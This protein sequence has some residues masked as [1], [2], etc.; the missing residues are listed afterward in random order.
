MHRWPALPTAPNT[1][2]GIAIH[3]IVYDSQNKPI[4]YIIRDINP[5][6]EKILSIK[7]KDVINKKA[8]EAYQIDEAP[9]LDMYSNVAE[10]M[11]PTYFETYFNRIISALM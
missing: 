5:K 4:N 3:D 2:E 6:F 8:T 10:T 9:Y 7:K 11:E 1:I